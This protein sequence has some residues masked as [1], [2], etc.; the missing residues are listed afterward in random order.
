MQLCIWDDYRVFLIASHAL[1]SLLLNVIYHIYI[2]QR[3]LS[4]IIIIINIITVII[5]IIIII[6]IIIIVIIAI[7]LIIV[8]TI[9]N[10]I[11]EHTK[12]NH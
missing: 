9:I 6:V 12:F 8:V 7:V 1:T 5:I 11:V 2:S 10:I 4:I 3:T